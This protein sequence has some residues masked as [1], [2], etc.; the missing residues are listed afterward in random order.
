MIRSSSHHDCNRAFS[1]SPLS[2]LVMPDKIGFVIIPL[3]MRKAGSRRAG[4]TPQKGQDSWWQLPITRWKAESDMDTWKDTAHQLAASLC[5]VMTPCYGP[6]PTSFLSCECPRPR[7]KQPNIP[8]GRRNMTYTFIWT[9]KACLSL[10]LS[11]WMEPP[12]SFLH[13]SATW[14]LPS[15]RISLFSNMFPAPVKSAILNCVGSIP[16]VTTC[17]MMLSRH[18]FLLLSCPEL[19]TAISYSLAVLSSS[20]T[21]LK[22]FRTMLQDSSVELLSLITYLPSFTLHWLPVEQKNWIQT[23]SPCL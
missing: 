11:I 17:H 15:T 8:T 7:S 6:L 12:F 20:F 22:K 4:C 9:R 19:I 14:A 13:L 16:S 5:L 21:N 10:S 18:W 3:L 1:E 2:S 23:A